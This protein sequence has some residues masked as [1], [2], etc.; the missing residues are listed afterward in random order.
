MHIISMSLCVSAQSEI[1]G[2]TAAVGH[3]RPGGDA[4][5]NISTVTYRPFLSVLGRLRGNGPR[6]G[7]GKIPAKHSPAASARCIPVKP[8]PSR[9]CLSHPGPSRSRRPLLT[10]TRTSA[11]G[12]SNQARGDPQGCPQTLRILVPYSP[13]GCSP[14]ATATANPG[15]PLD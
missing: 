6:A 3:V 9:S 7:P 15:T 11:P 12:K 8:T 14:L 13:G 2:R 5:G 10:P 4:E 1:I